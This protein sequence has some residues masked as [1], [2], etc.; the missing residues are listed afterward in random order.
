MFYDFKITN[1][2][3]INHYILIMIILFIVR[4]INKKNNH[5]ENDFYYFRLTFDP[6]GYVSDANTKHALLQ[7]HFVV[8]GNFINNKIII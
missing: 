1:I 8:L 4:H 2:N 5:L 6:F 7:E 3:A